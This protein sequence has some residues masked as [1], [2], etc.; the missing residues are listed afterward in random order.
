MASIRS[1]KFLATDPKLKDEVVMVGGHLD[2]W[3]SGTGA[4]DNGAGTV[5]AMEVMRILESL[6]VQPRRTIRVAPVDWRR[7]RRVRLVR[8]CEAAFRRRPAFDRSRSGEAAGVLA[9]PA[10]PIESKPEQ[11]NISGST[12]M[13]TTEAGRFAASTCNRMPASR[14]SFRQWME[15]LKILGVTTITM[16]DTGGTD[17]EAFDAVGDPGLPVHSGHAGLRRAHASLEHGRVRTACSPTTWRRPLWSR[18]SS[19]TTPRCAT[20][21]CHASRCLI[22]NSPR[23]SEGAAEECNARGAG[24]RAR[25]EKGRRVMPKGCPT[26]LATLRRGWGC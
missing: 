13:S 22:P 25:D 8:L 18:R 26:P 16:S 24:C 4:T 3:A 23:K 7:A 21:C 2:S 6:N 11:Q 15:P 19:S 10:G 14:R 20:R 12:S 17:H 5:V 1:R 9:K